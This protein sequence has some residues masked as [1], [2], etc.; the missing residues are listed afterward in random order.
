MT[1]VL[2][3]GLTAILLAA[4]TACSN[5]S[6]TSPSDL[7]STSSSPPAFSVAVRPSPI[8]AIRC[9]QQCPDQ[10]GAATSFEFAADMTID[11]QDSASIGATVNSITLT[12]TTEGHTLSPLTLS[13][14]DIKGLAGTNHVGGQAT[15]SVPLS[16]LYNTPSGNA[17]LDVSISLQG[18]DDRNNQVTA[19]GQ[20]S[21][22]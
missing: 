16:L 18:T 22:R 12:A 5:N 20:V 14:D 15:L 17:N 8:T 3:A 9:N 13:S 21:V 6:A 4:S 11:V 10:S 1:Q 7:N 19:A 2:R